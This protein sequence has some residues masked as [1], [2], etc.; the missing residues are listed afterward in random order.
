VSLVSLVSLCVLGETSENHQ[1]AP[2][3]TFSLRARDSQVSNLLIDISISLYVG[4]L[5]VPF[6]SICFSNTHEDLTSEYH[7]L[8]VAEWGI[9]NLIWDEHVEFDQPK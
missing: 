8:M 7:G 5:V 1:K 9:M 2:K 3:S 4:N 6:S